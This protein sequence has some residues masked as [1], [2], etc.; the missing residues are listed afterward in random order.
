MQVADLTD[1]I[2]KARQ[3][4]RQ[5]LWLTAVCRTS[6]GLREDVILSDISTDGC[7][8]TLA[9]AKVRTGQKVIIRPDTLEGLPGTVCWV[10]GNRA[11]V[12]F[13]RPL[14]GPVVDHLVKVQVQSGGLGRSR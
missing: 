7:G 12:K 5:P 9:N 8:I 6:T 10:I 1:D 11:G 3:A 4:V 14:Y 13:D 2:P